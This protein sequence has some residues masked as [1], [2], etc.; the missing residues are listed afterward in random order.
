MERGKL[1]LRD[2]RINT[3]TQTRTCTAV[4]H[5]CLL[6]D[7]QHADAWHSPVFQRTLTTA[8]LVSY[9]AA[10]HIMQ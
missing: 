8:V 10:F 9:V 5:T 2:I 6:P 4:L 1:H 3:W 7:E